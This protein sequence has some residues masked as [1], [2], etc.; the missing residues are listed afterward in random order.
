MPPS[1]PKVQI[2]DILIALFIATTQRSSDANTTNSVRASSAGRCTK[3]KMNVT[4]LKRNFLGPIR[5][6]LEMSPQHLCD[7]KSHSANAMGSGVGANEAYIQHG[8]T[9]RTTPKKLRGGRQLDKSKQKKGLETIEQTAMPGAIGFH[10][11]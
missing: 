8:V 9:G 11:F 7:H 4:D 6:A 2:K 5:G 10:D 3:P 1:L